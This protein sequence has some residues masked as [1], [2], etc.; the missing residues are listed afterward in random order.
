MMP[1]RYHE[2]AEEEL[3]SEIGYLELQA[4]GLGRRFLMRFGALKIALRNFLNPPWKSGLG[5]GSGRFGPFGIRS[6]IR[7]NEIAH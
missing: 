1:L 3:L 5:F 4:Q 7:L 6:S 2:A